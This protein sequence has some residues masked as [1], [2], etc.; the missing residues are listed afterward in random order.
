MKL[1]KK[2][3]FV[4]IAIIALGLIIALFVDGEYSVTKTVIVEQP[5]DEV[6]DYVRQ[7]K[8]QDEYSVWA[9]KDPNMKKSYSGTDG[10]VGF[11]SKWDSQVEDVGVGEQEIMKIDEGNR[12]DFKLRF[13]EPF[14]S[15]DDAFMTTE[16]I[17]PN[18]TKVTWAFKG[19]MAYPMNLMM[20]FMDMEEMLGPDLQKGLNNLKE[21][22]ESGDME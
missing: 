8:N 16:E 11:I 7:L 20:L 17:D 12:V 14:E 4:L 3:L 10:E 9:T 15:E 22:L 1:L 18:K 5:S 21:V 2:I 13:K 19:K 6:F